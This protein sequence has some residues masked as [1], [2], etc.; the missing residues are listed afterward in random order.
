VDE[1]VGKVPG[2]TRTKTI[3]VP[4]KLKDVYQWRIPEMATERGGR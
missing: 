4:W 3:M 1:V 2:V